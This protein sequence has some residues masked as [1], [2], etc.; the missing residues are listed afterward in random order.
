MISKKSKLT[1]KLKK[2]LRDL[3]ESIEEAKEV[4]PNFGRPIRIEEMM[5][6]AEDFEEKL[7]EIREEQGELDSIMSYEP[8]TNKCCPKAPSTLELVICSLLGTFLCWAF[9]TLLTI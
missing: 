8:H 5:E 4:A 9:I 3:K 2:K 6:N 1:P 7:R